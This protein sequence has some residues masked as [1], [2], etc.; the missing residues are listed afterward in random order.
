MPSTLLDAR[1]ITRHHGARTVLQGVDVRVDAGTRL[2]LIGPNGSGKSTLLRA[3]AGIE[4]LDGGTVIRHGTVG[5]LPQ[6]ADEAPGGGAATARETIMERIGVAGA[7]RAL[8]SLAERLTAGDLAAVEPHAGALEHWL[9][10]GGAD[11]PARV[12]AAASELGLPGAL[13]DRPLQQLSGGQAARAGLAALRAARFDVVLLDEPTNHLDD[14]GLARLAAL[15]EARAGGVVLVSHDRAL[16]GTSA[17]ELLEL[18]P[19]TGTA[20]AYAGG[21]AAYERERD[22]ARARAI[23]EHEQARD[24]RRALQDAVTATRARAQASIAK[25]GRRTHDNDKHQEEWVR[26]RAQG[27]QQRAGRVEARIERIAVPDRPWEDRPLTLELAA[28]ARRGAVIVALNGAVLRRGTWSLGPL[29]L[30][31]AHGDRMALLG[32][33]G[34]GKST[35]L[36]ALAGTLPLAA[37]TRRA[38]PGA[39]IARLGQTRAALAADVPLSEAVRALT[40]QDASAARTALAAV[41]LTA[42]QAQRSA[43]TLSPGE[44]TR[45]ELAVVG[46]QGAACLLLDE[47]TNH[48]DIASLEV[49]EQ[50]LAGWPG[51]LVVATHDA[52]LREALALTEEVVL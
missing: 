44:R 33:N 6:L 24:R 52:R 47:P 21:W 51:A 36:E 19:R 26:S 18:D 13:L 43:A 35:V 25:A 46:H 7:A 1:N 30:T 3:L 37:G 23:A 28:A 17:H 4:P 41:G 9:A 14:D 15:L 16:L 12:E 11:A 42:D 48:L 29:D 32:A 45:A 31:V 22:N 49:L 34:S 8:D 27:M 39:T 40:G 10:L 2:A 20:T 5:Y 38:A 50:A